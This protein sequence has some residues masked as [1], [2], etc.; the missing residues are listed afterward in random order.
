M[1]ACPAPIWTVTFP[2]KWTRMCF[3]PWSHVISYTSAVNTKWNYALQVRSSRFHCLTLFS[4]LILFTVLVPRG[5][6]VNT[7]QYTHNN[8]YCEYCLNPKDII[9][10]DKYCNLYSTKNAIVT[11]ADFD[12]VS[13]LRQEIKNG[14]GNMNQD[15]VDT[16]SSCI[17]FLLDPSSVSTGFILV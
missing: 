1:N 15:V 14:C 11:C 3:L 13:Y 6:C 7:S 16:C 12:T 10:A 5:E 2:W 4:F 9:C 8:Y 17:P